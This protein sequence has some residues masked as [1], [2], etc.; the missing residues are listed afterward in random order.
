MS[1][2]FL[3][4]SDVAGCAGLALAK[5]KT[6]DRVALNI[7]NCF[8]LALSG[9]L[10]F[11]AQWQSSWHQYQSV[12]DHSRDEKTLTKSSQ[13]SSIMIFDHKTFSKRQETLSVLRNR[14]SQK[15]EK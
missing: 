10:L 6:L 11:K 14:H 9:T 13:A 4:H 12:A 5:A 8:M 2:P 1:S 3:T 15:R 7:S